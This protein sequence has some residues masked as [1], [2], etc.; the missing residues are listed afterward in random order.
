MFMMVG[1]G[2]GR[3]VDDVDMSLSNLEKMVLI[4]AVGNIRYNVLLGCGSELIS[5]PEPPNKE[6]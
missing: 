1:Q 6:R 2:E 4:M 5:C 3:P